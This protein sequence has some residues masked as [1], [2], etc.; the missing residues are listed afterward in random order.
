MISSSLTFQDFYLLA[1]EL[2]LVLLGFLVLSLGLIFPR[3]YSEALLAVVLIG[4]AV[5][6]LFSTQ[7]WAGP[8][9]TAFYGMITVDKFSVGFRCLFIIRS[10]LW[11]K[12]IYCI[13]NIFR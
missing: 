12:N 8:P 10:I 11:K 2:T 4:F 5:S 7:H 3:L 13:V 6:L 9:A 1:P